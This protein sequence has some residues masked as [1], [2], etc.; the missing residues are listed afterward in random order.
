V[1][2]DFEVE[3]KG[4][5]GVKKIE[6]YMTE[7]DGQSWTKWPDPNETS[8]PIQLALPNREGLYGFRL[9]LYSGVMRSEGPPR[10][11][12]DTPQFRLLVDWTPPKVEVFQPVLDTNQPNVLILPYRAT[13]ANLV[14]ASVT[15]HYSSRHDGGWKAITDSATRPSQRWKGINDCTWTLPPDIPDGVYLK[16]TARDQA[17]NSSE[18]ITAE[19]VTVD[20]NKP[21][22]RVK[23]VT[24]SSQVRQ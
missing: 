14:P 22:A 19:P 4:P 17:G 8:S 24:P 11:G 20:L 21:T 2:I 6:V 7:D 16:L 23:T 3:R 10:P 5:S 12:V 9:V 15:L 18:F 1:Q 13:D